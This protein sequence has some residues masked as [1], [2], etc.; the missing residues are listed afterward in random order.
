[1]RRER[2]REKHWQI[3]FLLDL[4]AVARDGTIKRNESHFLAKRQRTRGGRE[5]RYARIAWRDHSVRFSL[6]SQRHHQFR[7]FLTRVETAGQCFW[8]FYQQAKIDQ[9][10][11]L[12]CFFLGE[13]PVRAPYIT[14]RF[15]PFPWLL[16]V[17]LRLRAGAEAIFTKL[18]GVKKIK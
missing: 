9:W 2:E 6:L 4:V 11:F 14:L 7:L 15:F 1:M 8:V 5:K 10:P 17:S 12:F 18:F 3:G 13:K 16:S